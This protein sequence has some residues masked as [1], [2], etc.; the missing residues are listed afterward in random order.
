MAKLS[1]HGTEVARLSYQIAFE[2]DDDD[3]ARRTYG[4][5]ESRYIYHLSFR[6][7]GHILRRI[8]GLD[9]HP[10]RDESDPGRRNDWGWKLYRRMREKRDR[11]AITAYARRYATAIEEDGRAINVEFKTTAVL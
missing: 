7:D 4:L 3:F 2:N 1:A 10:D 6:S 8:V 11:A 5:T 9:T